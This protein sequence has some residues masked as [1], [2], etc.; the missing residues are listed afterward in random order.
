MEDMK[1]DTRDDMPRLIFANVSNEL[2][3]ATPS[4]AHGGSL[5]E[6]SPRK[7]WLAREGDVVVTPRPIE[8][9]F[10]RYVCS[11]LGL[12]PDAI[13]TLSPG[14]GAGE[15]LADAVRKADLLDSLASLLKEREGIRMLPF[16]MDRPTLA[17]A[18]DLGIPIEG[19]D[20][21]PGPEVRE[22]IYRMNTKSGFRA[23]AAELGLPVVPGLSC[24]GIS[25]LP[26]VVEDALAKWG[27]VIVK[28]D[29]SSNGYGH[30]VVRR[31]A[32]RPADLGDFLRSGLA[33][34]ADQPQTFT[35]E[36][37]MPFVSV[38]SIEMEVEDA[39]PR[40]LY[41][42]DQRCPNGSF[43][44]MVTPPP[45]L[46]ASVEREL[47]RALERFGEHTHHAG[48]RGT[49]DIDAGVTDNGAVYL[50]ESN[51]R[52]TGGTYLHTLATRLLG[53]SY[54]DSHIWVAD[55]R[56]GTKELGFFDAL[57]A[58]KTA[59]LAYDSGA[60]EGVVLTADSV[61][62]DGR[63]RYLILAEGAKRAEA[64][65]DRLAELLSLTW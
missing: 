62:Y 52:R 63:W 4:V 17:L 26:G 61:G 22:L 28:L 38:P 24:E 13:V 12:D 9:D 23:S 40:F 14:S 49:C 31:A 53:E 29:R 25:V 5:R 1:T 30:L 6:V 16:A 64:I 10:K 51:F 44:G 43:S 8:E 42:C 2:M 35:V 47:H 45:Q 58:V 20:S 21:L 60:R 34:I 11:V 36:K 55:A 27:D 18:E 3:L 56:R 46:P 41:L 39:G 59:G 48:F 54:L 33:H 15:R 57:N 50:T 37:L 32:V 19:Y 7:M 65:E